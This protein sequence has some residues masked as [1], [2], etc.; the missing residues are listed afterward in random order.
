MSTLWPSLSILAPF[1]PL[2]LPALLRS[3]TSAAVGLSSSIS[4]KIHPTSPI[5]T[6]LLAAAHRQ[7]PFTTTSAAHQRPSNADDKMMG[8]SVPWNPQGSVLPDYPPRETLDAEYRAYLD[9]AAANT[10]PQLATIS[11]GAE[12]D[13]RNS[14]LGSMAYSHSSFT[15]PD[16]YPLADAATAQNQAQRNISNPGHTHPPRRST[17]GT[18]MFAL[19]P[20][21]ISASHESPYNGYTNSPPVHQYFDYTTHYTGQ[22][23]PGPGPQI[24]AGSNFSYSQQQQQQRQQQ[25][26]QDQP[27]YPHYAGPPVT[28]ITYPLGGQSPFEPY[29]GVNMGVNPTQVNAGGGDALG[30]HAGSQQRVQPPPISTGRRMANPSSLKEKVA[31]GSRP[32]V[33]RIPSNGSTSKLPP[34]PPPVV[35]PVTKRRR[36]NAYDDDEDE[37]S[38]DEDYADG[39]QYQSNTNNNNNGRLPPRLP[40]A[41][42]P[43]KRLKMKCV[44]PEGE[45]A[46]QRCRNSGRANQCVVGPRKPRQPSNKKELLLQKV[47]EQDATI[48]SKDAVIKSLL[49]QLQNPHVQISLKDDQPR[50]SASIPAAI[51]DQL[52]KQEE[53]PIDKAI[54]DWMERAQASIVSTS[55]A[56]YRISDARGLDESDSDSDDGVNYDDTMGGQLMSPTK[57][58]G[59]SESGRS[60]GRTIGGQLAAPLDQGVHSAKSSPKLHSLPLETTPIGL[61]AELSLRDQRDAQSRRSRSRSKSRSVASNGDISAS[62]PARESSGGKNG[63]E[64]DNDNNLGVASK[65]YFQADPA[66]Q[67]GLRTI[68]IERKNIPEIMSCGI[69]SPKEVDELFKIFFDRLNVFVSIL[70]PLLHTPATTFGRCPFLFT[71]VCAIS[72]R[73]YTEKRP[74]LYSL[75][76]HFARKAAASSL[77]EGAKSVELCQAYILMSVYSMPS[78]RW[79]DARE[80]LYLGLAIRMATDLNLH[81]RTTTKPLNEQHERELLNRSR[82]WLICYNLDRSASAQLGKPASIRAD[83]IIRSVRAVGDRKPWWKASQ[84]NDPFDL[85]LCAYTDLLSTIVAEFQER[86]YW[87]PNTETSVLRSDLDLVKVAYE[88]D[89]RLTKWNSETTVSFATHSDASSPQCAYRVRLLPFYVNYLRLVMLSL[90]FQQVT[91][92]APK[93]EGPRPE[94]VKRCL[95]AACEVVKTIV[96]TLAPTDYFRYAPDGHFVFTSFASAFLIKMLRLQNGTL[97]DAE[98]KT[99]VIA[100]VERL[101]DT[102]K[103]PRIAIDARHTPMLYSRFLASLISK[104]KEDM[105][106][107]TDGG[108]GLTSN[109]SAGVLTPPMVK[110]ESG[111]NASSSSQ[112]TR[113]EMGPPPQKP[114]SSSRPMGNGAPVA[115]ATSRHRPSPSIELVPAHDPSS[116]GPPPTAHTIFDPSLLI[117]DGHGSLMLPLSANHE[118]SYA[119]T[120]HA[121]STVYGGSQ[122]NAPISQGVGTGMGGFGMDTFMA[123]DHMLAPMLAMSNPAFWDSGMLPGMPA[124]SDEI[125]QWTSSLDEEQ[126]AALGAE[127]HNGAYV[128]RY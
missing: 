2:P 71:V 43:C 77:I 104:Y 98:E 53:Q 61:L 24:P 47:R 109:D 10:H 85:H 46:C 60:V 49:E 91:H 44:F 103:N 13:A 12:F 73:Y 29:A 4:E 75:A 37:E 20:E 72:S 102:L 23:Q 59:M 121:P 6:L 42:A 45:N 118:E 120:V 38:S 65:S 110:D 93:R 64:D 114:A 55:S 78:R 82:T 100:L 54:L 88:F 101:I 62:S 95:D 3:T 115:A 84:Y 63:D 81:V 69:V 27:A 96:D 36:T 19:S 31:Q 66:A 94:I 58:S 67:M 117:D 97:L 124:W 99:Q 68:K 56:G 21:S 123:D 125:M 83:P 5:L 79:E 25:Q 28:G 87:D 11:N 41:C 50:M 18:D 52:P 92:K 70:D 119:A 57:S 74:E 8:S 22:W 108:D 17:T 14:S 16:G 127:S 33:N 15:A 106:P 51:A 35:K 48:K 107:S 1:Q 90:G 34:P 39:S 7:S 105:A 128:G 9:S 86:V 40:G 126:L 113:G 76:M 80:W 30:G 32:P 122:Y 116:N 89:A 112:A 26:H 111:P